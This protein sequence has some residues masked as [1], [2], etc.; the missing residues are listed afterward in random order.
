[1]V[2]MKACNHD[3]F[4]SGEGRYDA[5]TRTLR[6]VVVCDRCHG[7]VREVLVEQYAPAFDAHGN[8]AYI[9]V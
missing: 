1:M 4:H 2:T 6:Y 3:G 8:D 5:T 9:R 7:E